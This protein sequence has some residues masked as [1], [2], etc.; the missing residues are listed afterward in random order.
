MSA[1]SS[2]SI[3]S[4]ISRSSGGSFP[5]TFHVPTHILQVKSLTSFKCLVTETWGKGLRK[6]K[7]RRG[8][9]IEGVQPTK[10]NRTAVFRTNTTIQ[11]YN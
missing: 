6:T 1:G 10:F 3:Q 11:V 7:E 4:S 5:P 9:K 8:K 2:V